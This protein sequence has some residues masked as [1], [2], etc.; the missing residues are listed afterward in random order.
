[1]VYFSNAPEQSAWYSRLQRR[2]SSNRTVG[3]RRSVKVTTCAPISWVFRYL[4]SK[5]SKAMKNVDPVGCI[6]DVCGGRERARCGLLSPWVVVRR[7]HRTD[8][9]QSNSPRWCWTENFM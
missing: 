8:K 9:L 5:A 2:P 7:L 1:M 4:L 6:L 3:F